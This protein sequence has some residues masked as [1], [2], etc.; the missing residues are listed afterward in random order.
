MDSNIFSLSAIPDWVV[1]REVTQADTSLESPFH[2]PLVDYQEL[3]L[4]GEINSYSHTYECINDE[5]RIENSSLK[6]VEIHQGSQSLLIHE[7]SIIRNGTKIDALDEENISVIQRERSLESHITDNR[8]TISVTIDDLRVGDHVEYISTIIERKSEHPFHGRHFHSNYGLSWSC[9]VQR[10]SV[11]I[12][13][14]SESKLSVLSQSLSAPYTDY[15]KSTIDIGGTFEQEFTDLAIE[16]IPDSAPYW[17]WGSFVHITSLLAWPELSKY[18]YKYL[19]DNNAMES[20]DIADIAEID[21]F[22]DDDSIGQKALK[23]IRFVQNNVRYRG[24]NHGIFTHTPKSPSRTLRKR[25]GDCKDKSNLMVSMLNAIG[26]P[27]RLVLV[28]TTHGIKLKELNP[29]PYQFNHM[30]VEVEFDSKIFFIDPTIQKQA[31]DFE[32]LTKL[33]YGWSL[34]LSDQGAELVQIQKPISKRVFDLAHYF[35]FPKKLDDATVEIKRTYHAHRADNMRA[36]F[37]SNEKNKYELDFCEWA[38][39]DTGLNLEIL[40]PISI[41]EDDATKNILTAKEKYRIL[42]IT[43]THPDKRVEVLTDFYKELYTPNS[44]DFPIRIDLDGSLQHDI[45][46][47][48]TKR[49]DFDISDAKAKYAVKGFEYEDIVEKIEDNQLH[50][51]TRLTPLKKHVEYGTEAKEYKATVEALRQRSNNLF[52]YKNKSKTSKIFGNWLFWYCSLIAFYMLIKYLFVN[53]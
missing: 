25:A 20:I 44:E 36:Y 13:N 4:K 1:K 29:S 6:L 10:Q 11:R 34:P 15:E 33:D 41:V 39:N 7:I 47:T 43:D 9:P 27:A 18:L 50:Y 26:V 52:P 48:Y 19:L 8:L 45:Y 46:V 28:S 35:D 21:I 24:E 2:F 23:I 14:Q 49:P 53:D 32:H 37:S 42:N 40:D 38:K 3:I 16:R 31:G 12:I 30:I 22:K 51:M 17:V 5:S